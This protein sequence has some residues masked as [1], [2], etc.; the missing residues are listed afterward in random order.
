MSILRF[1][2]AP[3]SVSGLRIGGSASPARG[4]SGILEAVI[5]TSM[6]SRTLSIRPGGERAAPPWGA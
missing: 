4:S 3:L 2:D 6:P 5:V 1:E